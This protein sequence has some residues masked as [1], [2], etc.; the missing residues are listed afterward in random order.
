VSCPVVSGEV[1]HSTVVCA[2]YVPKFIAKFGYV[3][4]SMASIRVR[5]T[6]SWPARHFA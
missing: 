4:R 6:A 1:Q 5:A 2:L 3:P